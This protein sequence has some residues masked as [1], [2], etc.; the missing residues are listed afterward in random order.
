MRLKKE[1]RDKAKENFL[2]AYE[3]NACNISKAARNISI[4]RRVYYK[5]REQDP[6]F[7]EACHELEQGM[8]DLAESQLHAN[9]LNGK[10]T[11]LIFFLTNRAPDRWKHIKAFDHTTG[12]EK[13]N[14]LE[15]IK[16]EIVTNDFKSASN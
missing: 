7:D 4:S 6:D 11:S 10:E 14:K 2:K 8:I 16:V 15:K 1:V 13:I 12:G 3:A 5:W 9:I